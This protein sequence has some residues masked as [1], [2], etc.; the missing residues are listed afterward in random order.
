MRLTTV[1]R[2]ALALLTGFLLLM[3]TMG[4]TSN[5]V[6]GYI[7]IAVMGIYGIMLCIFWRCPA[8]GKNLG[9]L[10]IKHCPHCGEKTF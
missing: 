4:F 2:I 1:K 6:F 10:W 5:T 8:C 7:A 9:A 3:M